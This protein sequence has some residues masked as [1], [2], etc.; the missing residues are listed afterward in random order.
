MHVPRGMAAQSA[1]DF[2]EQFK[3]GRT[4][5]FPKRKFGKG[6][7]E[8]SFRA[9]WCDKYEWLHYNADKDAA[10]CYLCMK[11]DHERKFLASTKRNQAFL[12]R[13]FTY[14]KAATTAFKKHQESECHREAIQAMLSPPKHTIGELISKEHKKE[15]EM[16]RNMFIRILQNIRYLAR[17]GLPF[18]GKNEDTDSNFIQLL[19]S[20]DSPEIIEWMRK[21]SNKYTSPVI[22]NEC[23]QIMA[24][25]IIRQVSQNIRDSACYTIMADECTDKSNKEQFTICMRWVGEDLQDH[26]DLIGLYEVDS[27]DAKSLVHAIR[28]TLLRMG[29]SLSLCRGQCY[30]GASNMSG[31]KGGVA[32]QLLAEEK[33]AVYTHCYAHGLNLTVGKTLKESKVCCDALD[34]AFEI[35]KLIKFSPKRNAAFDRIKS[36]TEEDLVASVG[37]RNFCPTRWTVR[38]NSVGSILENYNI[39]NDLWDECLGTRLEPDI[40][41]RIIGLKTQMS[42]YKLL[43][44]LHLCE[45]ILKITDNLSK[46]L[47]TQS[48]SAS[49]ARKIAKYTIQTLQEMRTDVMFDVFFEYVESLRKRTDTEEPILPRKRRV[50]SRYEVGE[51][52]GH[53]SLTIKDHYRRCYFESLDLVVSSIQERFDQRGYVV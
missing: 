51:G 11:T 20:S 44:G 40:K 15:Q 53:H 9:D 27:I 46:T 45:R 39:L 17:Q 31:S 33:R 25:R 23:L 50:P 28:D 48:L 14:W 12:S 49:E 24:L 21:K 6:K 4:Y 35:C 1:S 38:G 3:P 36:Q 13:G 5:S 10:F 26:E 29:L 37:I 47:Q 18:R 22:Q 42:Q 32:A 8:R 41:G 52:E 19:R 7:D 43:F 16:N 34:T 30:D 2:P